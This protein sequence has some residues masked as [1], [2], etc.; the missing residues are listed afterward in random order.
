MSIAQLPSGRAAER[1]VPGPAGVEAAQDRLRALVTRISEDRLDVAEAM[2]EDILA[3]QQTGT[4]RLSVG[5]VQVLARIGVSEEALA[6]P[7]ALPATM[8][9]RVR[10]RQMADR[11]ATVSEAATMLGVTAARVRQ[12][13]AAGTL[14]AQRRSDGWHLPLFQFPEDREPVG[15]SLVAKVIPLGTPLLLAERVL[16][17]PEARLRIG[18]EEVAPL[19]WL[20]QGGDPELAAAAVDDALNRLP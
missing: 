18:D 10:E 5:E 7:S 8:R 20:A 1:S 2:L 4:G 6:A 16:T 13:C 17:S 11:S 12:R 15:W 3:H 9:G 14:L 19:E